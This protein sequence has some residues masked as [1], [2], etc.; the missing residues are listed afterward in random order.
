MNRY[1]VELLGVDF[2]LQLASYLLDPSHSSHEVNEIT[3]RK[4]KGEVQ[5]DDAV[6]GKGAKRSIPEEAIV[7]EHI[8]RKADAIYHL[9][10]SIEDELKENELY[11]LFHELEMPLS[12]VLGRMERPGLRLIANSWSEWEKI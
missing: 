8:V 11:G 2:D 9:K 1:E 6:Y 12:I 4:G 5:S 3:A 7:S 10:E